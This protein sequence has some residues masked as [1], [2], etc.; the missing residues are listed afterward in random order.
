MS[1]T[2]ETVAQ[3]LQS[4]DLGDRLAAVNNLRTLPTEP[5]FQLLKQAIQDAN[6][7]VRYAAVSQMSTLGQQD[8]AESLE[9]LRDRLYQ[10]SE[11][12]VKAAAAD[13]IGAL[14]LTEAYPDLEAC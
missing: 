8:L 2:P 5:A 3:A 13:A 7:R 6:P 11:L 4:A 14:H 9:I 12:D 10:D 1:H